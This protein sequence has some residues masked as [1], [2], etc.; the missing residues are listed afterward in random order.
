MTTD[1]LDQIIKKKV[2]ELGAVYPPHFPDKDALWELFLLKRA[3]Q[4]SKKKKASWKIAASVLI[5][6]LG[7]YGAITV[8]HSNQKRDFISSPLPA[9]SSEVSDAIEF[10]NRHCTADNIACN[11]PEFRQLQDDLRQSFVKLAEID[12]KL[13]Q[14]GSDANLVR[15]RKRIETHQ[16]RI[17]KVLVQTL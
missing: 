11:T 6:I 5:F 12:N 1:P 3:N 16:T 7:G 2:E 13:H 9:G 4:K 17:I 15:A 14:Y 10:I 8:Y